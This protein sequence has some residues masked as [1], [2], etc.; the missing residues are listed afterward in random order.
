MQSLICLLSRVEYPVD[1]SYMPDERFKR[2]KY[3]T[4][5]FTIANYWS[6]YLV[7]TKEV[8]SD[9]PTHPGI[10]NLYLDE[11]DEEWTTQIEDFDYIVISAGHWFFRPMVFHENNQVVGCLY[12]VKDNV[13]DLPSSYGYRK[14]FRTSFKA[15][16]SLENFKGITF[17]RTFAP[18]HYENGLWNQG[19]DCVRTKPFGGNE[20]SLEGTD[21]EFYMTQL[22]EFKIA[23]KQGNKRGLKFRLL[24]TTQATLLRPD[25]HPSRYG[26]LKNE[27][28]TMRN[29]CVHWCLPGPID[30]WS[31]FLLEMLKMEDNY[32]HSNTLSLPLAKNNTP[33]IVLQ[34]T[35]SLIVLAIIPLCYPLL[36]YP[37]FLLKN[38]CN[39][40][41]DYSHYSSPS[42]HDS[43]R[44]DLIR[45]LQSEKRCDIFAGEWVPNPEGPYYTNTTCWAIHEH[46]NCM[47]YGRPDT[48]FMKWRWNPDGCDLPIFNPA[49]FLEIVRGKTLAFIGDSVARNQMQSLICLLSR[50]EYPVDVSYMP[51]ERFKRWKYTTYNFT[52]A[53]YW[54]PYLV[55]TKEVD[56]DV[57]T[58]PGIFNLYFDEFDEEWTTQ[59][60]DFDYIVISAGHWFF[61]PMVFHENNQVVGCLY[62]VKDNVTDLPSSYGYRK[63]FR[64]SFKAI[65]SLENFKGITFL[66]TFAPSHYENG[67]WNQGGDCVRTKPFGGNE[68]SLEGTDFEFYMTQLEEFKIAEKQGNKRGLKFRLLDTTQATVIETRW[69]S[70]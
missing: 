65:N 12:C 35:L 14:A 29:D 61:R 39:N 20:I 25:G 5:N 31:D 46:Q 30:T 60:E 22:E 17:L 4:Y 69:S 7:K 54:S 43:R 44:E 26:H 48:D 27:N 41:S 8:D 40:F 53:N 49:Q 56:S 10:F 51:D 50:V 68:I 18:S 34:I 32:T 59:I 6:P 42:S 38:S 70:K 23:E 58:H 15:I 64:T 9:V 28:V 66:R 57:P 1:V 21:F 47:K 67:L 2:W 19:G 45:E 3:T 16:N 24:D 55:K 62:C 52:I 37:L 11:F 33:K 13:T 63:A 36:G